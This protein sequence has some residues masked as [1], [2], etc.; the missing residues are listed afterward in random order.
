MGRMRMTMEANSEGVGGGERETDS[1]R[2]KERDTH[3]QR[4]TWGER[5]RFL[6][7][8]GL[9]DLITVKH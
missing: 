2:K 6:L 5:E 7:Q 3:R 1:Q 4:D 8:T 9:G